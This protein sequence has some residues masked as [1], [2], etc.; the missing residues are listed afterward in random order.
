[1][2]SNTFGSPVSAAQIKTMKESFERD[3]SS[4]PAMNAVSSTA[5]SRAA[6]NRDVVSRIDRSFSIHLSENAATSQ[7]SSGRCWLFAAL[8]TLRCTTIKKLNLENSFELSQNWMMFWD[9]FEKA[10]FFL[11]A[12]LD[13]ADEPEGSRIIDHLMQGP[14]QDGGQWHMFVSL[15]DKYGVIPKTA[16]P[17]T[18]SS[19]NT[20]EMNFHITAMLRAG[21]Q[22]LRKAKE[23]GADEAEL[24]KAKQAILSST[25]RMLCVHLGVPPAEIDWQWRDKDREFHR[26]GKITPKQFYDEFVG[27]DLDEM[28]CL[29]S[30]PRPH[31]EIGRALTV[32][33]LG[34]VV[35]GSPIRYLNVP[36]DEM[37]KAAVHQMRDGE[38]VWF[39]CDVG[40][41][42]DRDLGLMDLDLWE[43]DP[44]YGERPVLDKVGR[45]VYGQSMMTHAMVFTGVD[46]DEE[47]R[48]RRWRVENSWSEKPGDKGYFQM[49]DD[50][51]GQYMYEVVV[52]RRYVDE[53]LLKGLESEPIVLPPW[54]PMGSLAL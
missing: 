5:V 26:R 21:A 51:F 19:G 36:V 28:V 9:K 27:T 11:E 22:N 37:R 31:H 34:N 14:I 13:T 17:E 52:H 47:D 33:Y 50:W 49:T 46:L 12:I 8:N 1:M 44:I 40:K 32:D 48:P 38:S 15:V 41:H 53:K 54:D 24:Q 29:V 20:R 43:L 30:D 10:N 39:G 6:L 23:S 3:S 25:Y 42:L 35:G 2:D 45:L 4:R 7:M 18:K 16:M